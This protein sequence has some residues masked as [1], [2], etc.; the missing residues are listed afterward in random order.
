MKVIYVLLKQ[1]LEL[2][3][4]WYCSLIIFAIISLIAYNLAYTVVSFL[5]RKIDIDS[6]T[7][8]SCIH[9]TIRIFLFLIMWLITKNIINLIKVK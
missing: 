3:V 8:G 9:W 4:E 2:D 6:K 1:L 7:V 5:Y